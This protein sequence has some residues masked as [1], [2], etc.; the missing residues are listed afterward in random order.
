MPAVPQDGASPRP[1]VL[2]ID[3]GDRRIG[4][5]VSDPLGLTAQ[6]VTVLRTGGGRHDARAM[7]AIREIADR[8]EV[9][10]IVVGMPLNMDG[11][12]GPRAEAASAFVRRLAGVVALPIE[13]IDER[14]TTVEAEEALAEAGLSWRKRRDRVD[15]VAAQMILQRWLD[16][17]ASR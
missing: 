2:G 3:P 5:A 11:S 17:G 7:E 14:L 16:R 12:R 9:E 13:T 15:R 1:R 4:V 10:R 6:G 8:Y